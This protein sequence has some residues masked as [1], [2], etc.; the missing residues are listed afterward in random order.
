MFNS[1]NNQFYQSD[2]DLDPVTLVLKL[3]L[4]IVMI[5]HDTKNEVYMSRNSKVIARTDTQKDTH[6][7]Y[8]NITFLHTWAA[9]TTCMMV[10]NKPSRGYTLAGNVSGPV[11]DDC[12]IRS[13]C[14]TEDCVTLNA[15]ARCK[16]TPM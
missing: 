12:S 1:Q 7:Q 15:R 13:S 16:W 11:T 5:Y 2:L 4:D 6:R 9:I 8:E 14:S 10:T 3:D